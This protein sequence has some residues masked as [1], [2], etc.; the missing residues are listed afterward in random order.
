MQS[1]NQQVPFDL[2][3]RRK[4]L[5]FFGQEDFRFTPRLTIS[6]DLRW[7]LT[8]PLHVLGG[9]WSNFNVTAPNQVFGGI[10][11]AYTWLKNPN[12]SFETFTDWH[13]L[14]PKLGLAYQ[15][16]DK[17]VA[18]A[19]FGLNYVPLGWNGYSGVPYGSAVG[20]TGLNQVIEKSA[21]AP[22]FQWDVSGYP[23]V[24]TPPSGPDQTSAA[25]Q[26]S[27]G[28]ANIDPH[29]RQLAFTENWYGGLQYQLPSNAKLEVSYMG[30]TGRNLHDGALN[31]TNYPTWNTYQKLLN[32]GNIWNW[33]SDSSS[34]ASAGVPYPYPGFSGEAYF[35]INPFPQ[36]QACY[37]GGVFF[38]NSPMGQTGYNAITVEGSK[39]RGALNLDLSYNWSRTTGNTG[40][41]LFDT[42][43]TNYWWQDPYKYKY[44]AHWPHIYD[45]VKGYVS[46]VLPF[47]QGRRFLSDSHL[48]NYVVGGW[49][50]GTIVSYGN[51]SQIGAVGS[52]N[53]YPGWSAVYTNVAAHPNFK[54]PFKGYN[55]SWNPSI[56]GEAPDPNS[57][58]VD[59]S[60]FSNP[61][62]GQLG[63]SPTVFGNWRNWAGPQE[64]ASLLKKTKFGS[65][66]RYVVTLRAEF[67]DIFNRHYWNNPNTTFG[68]GYFGHVTGINNPGGFYSRTG[69]LGARFEW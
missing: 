47:G 44:E 57:L 59:P 28:P 16:T 39:Q 35:A 52:T 27:W 56:S 9:T 66:G 49:T 62:F 25:L 2:D 26:T 4:E 38:T 67:F 18:R 1:A 40:S 60:N 23:G 65:D 51:A 42:W 33:V 48:L 64:N 41:A 24:L 15:V 11:G 37:C 19:S 30:N 12:D 46:Y 14:A 31:P 29:S 36:V 45:T 3:S 58:F 63:N 61:T 50:A 34:A 7:E 20:F 68:S 6:A 53:S 13:Q 21:Q 22:A 8:R 17:L 55:P 69:Q 10:A 43:S 54:N 5:A 32:S